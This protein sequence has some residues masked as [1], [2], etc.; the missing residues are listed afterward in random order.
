MKTWTSTRT[1]KK[2]SEFILQEYIPGQEFTVN[3]SANKEGKLKAI[4][5]VL[6]NIKKGITISADLSKD[7]EVLEGCEKIHNSYNI[8]GCYNIQLIKDKQGLIKP[9]EINPRIST[10]TCLSIAAG[11][12]FIKNFI[13]KDSKKVFS[14][15]STIFDSNISLRR[16][17]YNK[18]SNKNT[19]T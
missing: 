15:R 13:D 18:I 9:F 16:F 6:V 10:T 11:V 8:G 2:R 4:V 14:S 7:K 19:K 12:D 1:R 5:P 17:W 3:I